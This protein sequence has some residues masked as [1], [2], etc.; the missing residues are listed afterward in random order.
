[1]VLGALVLLAGCGSSSESS[2]PQTS[3]PATGPAVSDTVANGA[4][5]LGSGQATMSGTVQGPQGPATGATVQI[6]RAA[7]GLVTR[8]TI[9]SGPG[10]A[11]T[12]RGVPGGSYSVRTWLPPDMAQTA[13]TT[14]FLAGQGNHALTLELTSFSTP[15]VQSAIAPDPPVSGQ[16][17]QVVVQ[18]TSRRVRADGS[19]VNQPAAGLA[20][21]LDGQGTWLIPPP[22]P[23]TTDSLGQATWT[24][25]CD[26]VGSQP[27]AAD[28]GSQPVAL[29]LSACV[30]PPAPTT[31]TVPLPP[32][33]SG[34]PY[35]TA[36]YP[37]APYPTAPYPTAPY[38]TAPYPT[39]PYPS[40]G[41]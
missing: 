4:P 28:L 27:L 12:V 14:F 10:G 35:P 37:T 36:P 38:S 17:A 3:P 8:A 31:T 39:A 15:L 2:P 13:P 40:V 23:A 33:G 6:E 29:T 7:N 24:L 1:M 21:Q 32:S 19:V 34:G 30:A 22:N 41:P 26:Q 9:T 11:W 5:A 18:V 20:V 16:P 25:T